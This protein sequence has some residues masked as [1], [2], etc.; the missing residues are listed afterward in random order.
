MQGKKNIAFLSNNKLL[1]SLRSEISSGPA[2]IYLMITQGRLMSLRLIKQ[3]TKL[4]I[5]LNFIIDYNYIFDRV[6][7]VK[8]AGS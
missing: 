7:S 3:M 4:C 6:I 2:E 1:S 5:T 8:C